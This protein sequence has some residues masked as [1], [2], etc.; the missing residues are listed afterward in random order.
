MMEKGKV[1]SIFLKILGAP[2]LETK[3]CSVLMHTQGLWSPKLIS[4]SNSIATYFSGK[5]SHY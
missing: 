4:K 5:L 2:K 3:M 1:L